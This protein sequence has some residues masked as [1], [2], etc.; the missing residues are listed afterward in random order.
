MYDKDRRVYLSITACGRDC[1]ITDHGEL[2][3][4]IRPSL[5]MV[6]GNM[7]PS[8]R[9]DLRDRKALENLERFDGAGM[10]SV[11]VS[12]AEGEKFLTLDEHMVNSIQRVL[13]HT[14]ARVAGK[15]GATVILGTQVSTLWS[16]IRKFRIP[17]P[18]R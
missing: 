2:C 5:I 6:M 7:V 13:G 12:G 1:S 9:I 3:R 8:R 18:R 15:N 17:V 14:R 4:P 11:D 10:A 16:K